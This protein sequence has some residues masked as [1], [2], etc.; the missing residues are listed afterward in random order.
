M[1]TQE[2]TFVK[3]KKKT[4]KNLRIKRAFPS[5]FGKLK[6]FYGDKYHLNHTTTE[7]TCKP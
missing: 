1:E 3:K 4:S 5:Y 2:F 7:L 6:T